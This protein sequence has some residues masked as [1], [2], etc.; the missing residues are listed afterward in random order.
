MSLNSIRFCLRCGGRNNLNKISTYLNVRNRDNISFLLPRVFSFF[1]RHFDVLN[2]ET[3]WTA[4][5]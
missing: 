1:S 2:V 5:E 3:E 4:E